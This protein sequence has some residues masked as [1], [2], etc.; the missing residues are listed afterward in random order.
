MTPD[1][2]WYSNHPLRFALLPLSW[3]FCASVSIR[4]QAYRYG[5]LP[6]RRLSIP[7]IVVGNITVGGTGKTP[8]V[9]WIAQLLK[10]HGYKPGIVSRGYGG[11]AERW[12]QQ[13]RLDS[14][15]RVVG[16]EAI[17]LAKHSG[18]PVAVAPKRLQ[19]ID[20]LLSYYNCNV[21][22]SDDGLQHYALQRDIEI[23]VSDDIR[24]YGN[25]FC[26]P[27]GPLRESLNRLKKVDFLVTKGATL[28]SHMATKEFSMHYQIKSLCNLKDSR[29][30]QP[31]S[32]LRG[33][34]VHAVAGIGHPER[35]FIRLRDHGLKVHEHSF[36]DH[37][38]FK[39]MDIYFNDQL[40]VIMTEK[41]AV[42]CNAIADTRH[43]FLPI[44]AN[45]PIEFGQSLLNRLREI[46]N[47]QKIT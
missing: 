7:V 3:L 6:S 25:Q 40:P 47:G 19:A 33:Q 41:D 44:E 15:P 45:L 21:I 17:L 18:C 35:F 1:K 12:P 36:P 32:A 5:L 27:A 38:P 4:R 2:I 28:R 31:L 46:N 37:Y 9:I 16:D 8:L 14:D 42:K 29:V 22:I 20:S 13:V 23:Q 43:W 30:S 34:T 10:Q 26:L 39:K 24:R 11:K